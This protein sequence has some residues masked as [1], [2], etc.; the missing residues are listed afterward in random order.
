MPEIRGGQ[1]KQ[2]YIDKGSFFTDYQRYLIDIEKYLKLFIEIREKYS[3]HSTIVYPD[4]E[5]LYVQ[6]TKYDNGDEQ[7]EYFFTK[8]PIDDTG[9]RRAKV[10]RSITTD[11]RKGVSELK[12]SEPVEPKFKDHF[13]DIRFDDIEI[14]SKPKGLVVKLKGKVYIPNYYLDK[15]KII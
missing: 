2:I 14:E 8:E 15:F 11:W 10:N 13:K 6:P 12:L 1:M 4:P 9:I 3:I 7:F 5:Y